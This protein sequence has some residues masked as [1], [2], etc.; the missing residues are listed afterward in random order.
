MRLR[1]DSLRIH[2]RTG[3]DASLILAISE[4]KIYALPDSCGCKASRAMCESDYASCCWMATGFKHA[5]V[6]RIDAA[7]A[8]VRMVVVNI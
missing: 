3:Y 2:G 5:A 8:K 1:R 6:D 4:G 7:I